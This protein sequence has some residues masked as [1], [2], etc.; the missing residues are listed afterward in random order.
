MFQFRSE[1]DDEWEDRE[2]VLRVVS[3][4]GHLLQFA[5]NALRHDRDVVLA[6]VTNFGAAIEY[7]SDALRGDWDVMYAAVTNDA[8]ALEWATDMLQRDR[9]FVRFI[10][11]A[12]EEAVQV[13]RREFLAD[14][15]IVLAALAQVSTSIVSLRDMS[16]RTNEV[17]ERADAS[18]RADRAFLFAAVRLRAYETLCFANSSFRADRDLVLTAMTCNGKALQIV[19][20]DLRRDPD[21]VLAAVTQN[22]YALRFVTDPSDD[23]IRAAVASRRRAARHV[24]PDPRWERAGPRQVE[25]LLRRTSLPAEV[26][27]TY[28]LPHVAR[29]D[30]EM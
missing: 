2:A 22:G 19:S 17:F 3:T 18:L 25:F 10:V 15:D 6:A 21:V 8:R 26:V 11:S 28:I 1:Y 4:H 9:R 5:S 23:V 24:P 30:D 13:V 16:F 7:A 29:I 27:Q 12:N 14:P 20:A